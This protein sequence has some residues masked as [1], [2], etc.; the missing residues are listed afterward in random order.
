MFLNVLSCKFIKYCNKRRL[1]G[2]SSIFNSCS[3]C[4]SFVYTVWEEGGCRPVFQNAMKGDY[5]LWQSFAAFVYSLWVH[6][7]PFCTYL[8]DWNLKISQSSE[9]VVM[10]YCLQ[11]NWYDV[12][13]YNNFY[14]FLSRGPLWGPWERAKFEVLN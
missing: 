6:R 13:S 8:F 11:F 9:A 2:Q 3:V 7:H 4:S 5:A 10:G 12:I 14:L 1:F